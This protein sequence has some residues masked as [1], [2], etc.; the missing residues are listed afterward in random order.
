[1]GKTE[2]D[3][4]TVRKQKQVDVLVSEILQL[5]LQNK[6]GEAKQTDISSLC[7]RMDTMKVRE[8][9]VTNT[10]NNKT[11][12]RKHKR[13]VKKKIEKRKSNIKELKKFVNRL[14]DN[15][16]N[17][18]EIRREI[19]VFLY[20]FTNYFISETL[21]KIKRVANLITHFILKI[22]IK[23]VF[24]AINDI[25]KIFVYASELMS[26]YNATEE[27]L[28]DFYFCEFLIGSI[29]LRVFYFVNNASRG[30]SKFGCC[31]KDFYF[32]V[33]QYKRSI[34]KA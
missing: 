16:N 5:Q 3:R 11:E 14:N 20:K 29:K 32:Y 30:L 24:L 28:N 33:K 27:A 23:K 13:I 2:I 19:H 8:D 21:R 6:E 18:I 4:N 15:I 7:A 22:N 34:D 25:D 9:T 12:K 1:M 10:D 31:L 26:I 17:L